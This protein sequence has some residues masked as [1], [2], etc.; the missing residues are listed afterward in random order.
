M[1]VNFFNQPYLL[2]VGKWICTIYWDKDYKVLCYPKDWEPFQMTIIA[3]E[4]MSK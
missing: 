1:R 3:V 2:Y 4:K